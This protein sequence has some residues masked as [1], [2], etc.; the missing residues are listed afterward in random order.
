MKFPVAPAVFLVSLFALVPSPPAAAAQETRKLNRREAEKLIAEADK[1]ASAGQ[2]ADARQRLL[3]LMQQDP[4]NA[5]LALK[6]AA[7][8]SRC[9]TGS[10]PAPLTS[11]LFP[12]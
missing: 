8:V 3:P 12:I 1:L 2:L 10:A 9:L 11:W 7:S 4:T 6:V 5:P